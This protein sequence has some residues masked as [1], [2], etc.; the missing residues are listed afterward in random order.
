MSESCIECQGHLHQSNP[1]RYDQRNINLGP[2]GKNDES[3]RWK[4]LM[5]NIEEERRKKR[6]ARRKDEIM[7]KARKR[8]K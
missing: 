2:G 7:K 6:K 8:L 3:E 5:E 1:P 4:I